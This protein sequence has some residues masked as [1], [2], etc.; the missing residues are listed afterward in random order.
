MPELN[1]NR[2]LSFTSRS[3]YGVTFLYKG[4]GQEVPFQSYRMFDP[5]LHI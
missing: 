1:S 5:S 3:V 2:A 4:S